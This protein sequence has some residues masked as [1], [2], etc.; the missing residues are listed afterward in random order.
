MQTPRKAKPNLLPALAALLLT[1][2]AHAAPPIRVNVNGTPV[3]FTGTPPTEVKGSVLVPLRG[4]FQALGASVNYNPVTRVITAEKGSANVTLPLGSTTATVNGQTQTLSQPAQSVGGTTLVPLRFIAQALGASVQWV[5]AA[6][7]VEIKTAEPHLASLPSSPGNGAVIG[8]VTGVYANTNP[9][10]ITVRVNGQDTVVPLSAST[11]VLRSAPGQPATQVSLSQLQ[12]GDQVTVQRDASGAAISL[13]ATYGEVRGTIK[14]ISGKLGSGGQ[15]ITLNDGTTVET[16]PNV[17]VTMAGR[18]V[19]LGDVMPN[20]DIVIRTNPSN[21]LGY[22]IAVVTPNN[23]NPTPPGQPIGTVPPVGGAP[24]VTS[25][26]DDVTGPLKAGDKITVTMAG[27]PGGK[28]AFSI[29][30]VVDGYA[31]RETS[32]GVYTGTYI[33]PGNVSATGAA[34]LGSLTVN[35]QTAP[36]IQA[37]GVVTLGSKPPT[38][39]DFS[40]A[41]GAKTSADRPLIYATLSD[42]GGTGVNPG[43][44]RIIL[45]GA[46][47][48]NQATVTPSFFNV[49]PA[50]PLSN[51]S[52][53]VAVTVA[54]R[55]GNTETTRWKFTVA[56]SGLVQSFTS[57]AAGNQSFGAGDVVH[58]TLHA[59]PGGH[60][61]VNVGSIA[62]DIPL[63][64]T[65]PG[66]YTGE[67][68]VKPG[69]SIQNAPV[70]AQ[71]QTADGQ[72]VTIPLASPLTLAA[73][74]PQ[75]PRIT[76]PTADSA[77]SG[78]TVDAQGQAAPGATVR[79]SVTY[80]SKA[81][82]LVPISG[83]ADTQDV[84]ADKNGVWKAP[85]LSLRSNS[86]LG[87]G[88]N[89]TFTISAVTVA[90]NGDLS[91]PATVSIRHQ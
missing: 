18:N 78:N 53:T 45:D 64:E 70:S 24:S 73:G 26:T 34:V 23:P 49:R 7:T 6:N 79:V 87:L 21:K 74:P 90:P 35:G 11:I 31:L 55:A 3:A 14:S 12:P 77:L 67:Y 83:T 58:F 52:H 25:F 47:I 60:A 76:S 72:A 89:P 84:K 43:A 54:D 51:G 9:Q 37:A 40:P 29:P 86:L 17:P 42:A 13:T 57:S 2:A 38:L 30:G 62:S 27:T 4:V 5:A 59:Q 66:V 91:D 10:Q 48:T 65:A 75:A 56:P 61:L 1:A 41:R 88:S 69:D 15:I 71:F 85:G 20:E 28:A 80:T 33:V 22:G 46:D 16:V 36:L 19:T 81:F 63:T 44:T 39:S 68:A 32:P 50:Q 8:Q 82:G